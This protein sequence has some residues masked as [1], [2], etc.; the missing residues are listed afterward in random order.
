M[1]NSTTLKQQNPAGRK[2]VSTFLD[3]QAA[4]S[5][6]NLGKDPGPRSGTVLLAVPDC[7]QHGLQVA[8]GEILWERQAG[9]QGLLSEAGE[10]A[11]PGLGAPALR[12]PGLRV[13]RVVAPGLAAPGLAAPG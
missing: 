11:V 6:H 5:W 2:G 7:F 3:L 8:G 4:S 13:P 10:W 12:V 9:L 1:R